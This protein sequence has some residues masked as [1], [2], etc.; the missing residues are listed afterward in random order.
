MFDNLSFFCGFDIEEL[1][2]SQSILYGDIIDFGRDASKALRRLKK[3][4]K[5]ESESKKPS[6]SK[7]SSTDNDMFEETLYT[8]Y[9]TFSPVPSMNKNLERRLRTNRPTVHFLDYVDVAV[10]HFLDFY[11]S[12][13]N[14]NTTNY[15]RIIQN[16]IS[17]IQR[18]H[19]RT[20][21]SGRP[22][23]KNKNA[24]IQAI[25]RKQEPPRPQWKIFKE[26]RKGESYDT[27]YMIDVTR[28]SRSIRF[29]AGTKQD[30]IRQN[31]SHAWI[32]TDGL[33]FLP[34]C[35][36]TNDYSS[37]LQYGI[38]DSIAN[39]PCMQERKRRS[40]YQSLSLFPLAVFKTAEELNA[41]SNRYMTRAHNKSWI[42]FEH[43][44]DALEF[45]EEH[46][47][48]PQQECKTN[49]FPV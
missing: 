23:Q 33:W 20:K 19:D 18:V 44:L 30:V 21:L 5:K 36:Q 14:A 24:K 9:P 48:L 17:V 43:N 4:R 32:G 10:C 1:D 38:N 46:I 49:D 27:W 11:I 2:L 31:I 34:S 29:K 37:L 25:D 40:R 3:L 15:E 12:V 16:H 6:S 45:V 22:F 39:R 42:L 28:R 8:N 7:V 41:Y 13:D 35:D 26:R 47:L